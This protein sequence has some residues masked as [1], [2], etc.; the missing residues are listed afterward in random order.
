MQQLSATPLNDG[1]SLPKVTTKEHGYSTKWIIVLVEEI[2]YGAVYC[3]GCML[4][5]HRNFIPDGKRCLFKELV[6][7]RTS[8]YSACRCFMYVDGNFEGR[9]CS[10]TTLQKESSNSRRCSTESCFS[11]CPD[12]YCNSVANKNISTASSTMQEDDFAL[13]SSLS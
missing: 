4:V 11:L 3:I 6:G 12:S 8:R 9:M 5:L 7:I 1:E 10:V 2:T 13:I